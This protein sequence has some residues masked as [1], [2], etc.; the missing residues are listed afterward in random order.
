MLRAAVE[1]RR[2]APHFWRSHVCLAQAAT[3]DGQHD[4]A[5]Q[6]AAT[7]LAIAPD[8]AD[9]H[10]TAGKAA[11]SRGDL[12]E[13]RGWQEAALAIEPAHS[14]AINELG[15]ISLRLARRGGGR[16]ALPARGRDVA[17]QRRS[18]AATPSWRWPRCAPAGGVAVAG[19]C[20][21]WPIGLVLAG[22]DGDTAA[23]LSCALTWLVAA[24][25]RTGLG[26]GGCHR[27]AG[28]ICRG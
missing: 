23:R 14:G 7:A 2:L 10:V 1:A 19:G 11:L 22:P 25:T 26:S 28:A 12:A 27:R 24:A 8:V 5:L 13:A 4:L 20:R 16:R 18:S 15:R 21:S 9:V 6:A 17:R 3:A